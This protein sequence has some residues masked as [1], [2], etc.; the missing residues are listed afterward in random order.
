MQITASEW[1]RRN[2]MSKKRVIQKIEDF[3]PPAQELRTG[4]RR[5]W[6]IEEDSTLQR[7]KPWGRK[8]VIKTA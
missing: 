5:L 6:L 8:E 3:D 7:F 1:G 2:G 4:S